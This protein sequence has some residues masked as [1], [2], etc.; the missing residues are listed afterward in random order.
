MA[1]LL[2]MLGL[3]LSFYCL[4]DIAIHVMVFT[5]GHPKML[6]SGAIDGGGDGS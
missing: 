4:K 3:I 1:I 6:L 5:I 2:F